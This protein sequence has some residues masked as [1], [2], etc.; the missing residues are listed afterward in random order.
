MSLISAI[1]VHDVVC[2]SV[3]VVDPDFLW[4]SLTIFLEITKG[5]M[6]PRGS[7]FLKKKTLKKQKGIT[8]E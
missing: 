5:D 6:F 3:K 4:F 8:F 2:S 7:G 1:L